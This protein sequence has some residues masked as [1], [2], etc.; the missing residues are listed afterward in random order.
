MKEKTGFFTARNVAYLAILVALVV[1]LQ[2]FASAVPVFGI[3]LNFSLIPIAL[4]GILLGVLGGA[5]VG[6]ASGMVT[7]ITCAIMGMEPSTAYLFQTSPV[8]LTI[9]CLGKTTLAGVVAGLLYRPI[10]RKN[11]VV[12]ACVSSLLVPV[13]NTGIYMLGMVLMKEDVAAFCGFTES[14]ASA[15]FIGVFAI[16]WLNFVLEMAVTILLTPAVNAVVKAVESKVRK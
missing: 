8:I 7:F 16:I 14:T 9:V 11:K 12:A 5:I 3:T 6:F 2:M 4:A 15:V 1:V 13:V 10:A